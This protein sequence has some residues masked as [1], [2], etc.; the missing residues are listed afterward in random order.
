LSAG[1]GCD[2]PFIKLTDEHWAQARDALGAAE[3]HSKA[4]QVWGKK[5]ASR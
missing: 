5:G 3:D 1:L 2:T 4:I